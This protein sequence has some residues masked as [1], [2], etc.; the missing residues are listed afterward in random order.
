MKYSWYTPSSERLSYFTVHWREGCRITIP[1]AEVQ[2][3]TTT[4]NG[5]IHIRA[6]MIHVIARL[7]TSRKARKGDMKVIADA[8][9]GKREDDD[10]PATTSG[11][12]V[13]GPV[14]GSG[15]AR[16]V[17]PPADSGQPAADTATPRLEQ[18]TV[19]AF[20]GH[21]QL[22]RVQGLFHVPEEQMDVRVLRMTEKGYIPFE[23][24]ESD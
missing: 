17:D 1:Y 19:E 9:T 4:P 23:V 24:I 13:T 14:K 12:K 22:L 18:Q 2:Y 11:K 3:V 20:Q 16:P 10:T 7:G 6:G 15:P 8:L 21:F 5:T